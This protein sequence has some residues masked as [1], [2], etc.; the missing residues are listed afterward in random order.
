MVIDTN[1]LV[2]AANVPMHEHS[3]RDICTR[4]PDFYRFPFL[5]VADP[6]RQ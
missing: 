4:D 5:T 3:I 6:L 1:V 2:Y